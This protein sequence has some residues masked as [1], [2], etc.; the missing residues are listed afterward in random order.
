M[1]VLSRFRTPTALRRIYRGLAP[2]YDRLVPLVSS[3]ARKR[4]CRWLEVQDGEQVLDAGTGTGLALR[5]LVSANPSGWTE[6]L[7]ASTAMLVRA[8]RRLR[9]CSDHRYGLRVGSLTCL[10]YPTGTFDAAFSSYAVD[11]LPRSALSAV[12]RELRR[13]LRSEGR[14]VLVYIAP[15]QSLPEHLWAALARHC[16]PLLGGDRPL[17]LASFLPDAGFQ[18]DRRGSCTQLGLRSGL[19]RAHPA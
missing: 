12:L 9:R 18:I 19:V 16:P 1:S 13:V 10:P 7:D 15:P 2:V 14:L 17:S 3:R 8:R 4:G 5:P 11:V 6:G